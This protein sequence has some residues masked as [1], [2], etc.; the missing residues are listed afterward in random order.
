MVYTDFVMTRGLLVAVFIAITPAAILHAES[1]S[2]EIQESSAGVYHLD[3]IDQ[4]LAAELSSMWTRDPERLVGAIRGAR[5]D[6]HPLPLTFLLAVAHA[7]TNGRILLVSEA[8]AVGL[9][10]TTPIAYL[11]ENMEGRLYVT[12][13]YAEGARAYFLKKPLWD[14]TRIATL[15]LEV[16]DEDGRT[17]AR[18]LLDAAFRYRREGVD[19]LE[20]LV[21]FVGAGFWARANEQDQLNLELLLRLERMMEECADPAEIEPFRDQTLERYREMRDEQQV[22]WKYYQQDLS[23]KRD[24]VL[25]RT[26]GGDPKE[27]IRHRAWEAAEVLAQEL[28]DRFSPVSMSAFLARHTVRKFEEARTFGVSGQELIQLTAG[29]YNGGGHNLKRM[30]SGLIRSLTETMNYMEKVPATQRRLEARLASVSVDSPT[31]P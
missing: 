26:F 10:Q 14:V 27:V 24:D 6:D 16:P 19:D 9:A 4:M 11:E 8:G 17:Q 13:E 18:E 22:S 2:A 28:D 21:P 1:S 31:A 30:R 15:L 7:E 23:R 5:H 12:R 29:L 25:R 3:L 20:L